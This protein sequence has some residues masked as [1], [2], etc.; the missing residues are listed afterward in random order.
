MKKAFGLVGIPT[1]G[2]VTIEW[3]IN[4]A[5]LGVGLA[6]Y[7]VDMFV[8][9]KRVDVAKNELC[10][11]ALDNNCDWIFLLDD[12]V[13]PPPNT[14]MKMINLWRNREDCQIINGV[15]WSKSEP[16]LPLI[17]RDHMRGSYLDWH[18]GDLIEADAAGAGC[19]FIDTDVLRK[20]EKPWFSVNYTYRPKDADPKPDKPDFSTT[21]DLYFYHNARKLG[22]KVWVDTSIQCI[23]QDKRT[24]VGYGIRPDMPQIVAG[25][26]IP[27]K[28][29]KL[30]LD[31][32]AGFGTRQYIHDQGK[33]IRLDLDESCKPDIVAD[34]SAI[35]I[36]DQFFDI[37]HACHALEHISFR[38]ALM[39]LK[40]W[41]RVLKIGGTMD[42]IVPNLQWAAKN[43]LDDTLEKGEKDKADRTMWVLYSEQLTNNDYHKAG[44]TPE[45]L[46]RLLM[47]VGAFED[48]KTWTK[49]DEEHYNIYATAKK[50]KHVNFESIY[51]DFEGKYDKKLRKVC[52]SSSK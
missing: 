11:A 8:K 13:L 48:I 1:F 10:Q 18:V 24:G 31:I 44:Y 32:G 33:V 25:T 9:E 7:V 19:T 34:W 17:F 21:E 36:D 42:L 3:A 14:I 51:E 45:I 46:K 38:K 50:I 39:V 2:D 20:M 26:K 22:Y 27:K 35:P 30:I 12:D 49:E 23:H 28:G 6:V 52:N 41:S 15:Y 16:P 4:K 29:E 40:E 47:Q 37:V 43:I 5:H